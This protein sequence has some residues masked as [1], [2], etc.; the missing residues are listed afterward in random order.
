V[1]PDGS[2]TG[3]VDVPALT[4]DPATITATATTQ[5]GALPERTITVRPAVSYPFGRECGASSPA[6]ALLL[7]P[8]ALTA[9]PG[10]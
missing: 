7:S 1:N 3:F 2:L 8:A 6:A 9:E 10:S 5:A 4:V